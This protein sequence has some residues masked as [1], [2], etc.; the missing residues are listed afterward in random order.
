MHAFSVGGITNNY[1]IIAYSN[2]TLCAKD[3][4][5]QTDDTIFNDHHII[6]ESM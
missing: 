3:M 1:R 6:S 4:T 2:V 5:W